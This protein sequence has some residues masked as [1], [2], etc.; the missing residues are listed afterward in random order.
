MSC[1]TFKIQVKWQCFYSSWLRKCFTIRIKQCMGFELLT[2]IR[3]L[4]CCYF[5]H[6]DARQSSNGLFCN[7]IY[8][9]SHAQTI[10]CPEKVCELNSGKKFVTDDIWKI[11]TWCKFAVLENCIYQVMKHYLFLLTGTKQIVHI[12]GIGHQGVPCLFVSGVSIIWL[13]NTDVH[14]TDF[15]WFKVSAWSQHHA[16]VIFTLCLWFSL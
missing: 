7:S 3:S 8:F 5:Y 1:S 4:H 14:P 15:K 9:S 10:M 16:Q 13:S 11:H 2:L 6:Y 12:F